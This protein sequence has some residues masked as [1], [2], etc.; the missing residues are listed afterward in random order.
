M[1]KRK[2]ILASSRRLKR[3]RFLLKAAFA[4]GVFLVLFA[5]VSAMFYIPALRIKNIEIRGNSTL[6]NG[7]ITSAVSGFLREKYFLIIPKDNILIFPKEEISVE[8]MK[9]FD[10]IEKIKVIG[11]FPDSISI[12]IT[13]RNPTALFCGKNFP[14]SLTSGELVCFFVDEN[15]MVFE[16]APLFSDNV[17]VKFYNG[18]K[19]GLKKINKFKDLMK[20]IEAALNGGV[21]IRK[22]VLEKEGLKKIYTSEGWYIMLNE[23]DNF[24]TAFENLKLA[25]EEKIKD[26]RKYLEYIDLRFG[27]KLFYKYR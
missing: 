21:K 22:I 9:K 19:D 13:E 23:G 11:V 18:K 3:K 10:R 14:R 27:N 5:V 16:K 1:P 6:G 12:N 7:E 8:L 20:F 15:G 24:Q 25:L 26:N 4:V 2:D 17:Y